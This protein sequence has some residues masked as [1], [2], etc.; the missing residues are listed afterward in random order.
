[1]GV[2][3]RQDGHKRSVFQL[4][5][6]GVSDDM[7]RTVSSSYARLATATREQL[8]NDALYAQYADRQQ[9]D[10]AALQQSELEAI[11][12]RLDFNAVSGL[13]NELSAKLHQL[14]PKTIAEAAKLEGMTPAALLD[15]ER[16][17]T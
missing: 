16:C 10:A 9:R 8:K 1:M 3:V 17:F 5:G 13:S 12:P 14:R 7:L 2:D 11:D 6:A 15:H 4:I